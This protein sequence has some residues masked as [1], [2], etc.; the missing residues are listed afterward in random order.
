MIDDALQRA[1]QDDHEAIVA[2][3]LAR[4]RQM[5]ELYPN[6]WIQVERLR[7]RRGQPGVP[8]WPAWCYLP[9]AA[10]IAVVK[11][12]DQN[13]TTTPEQGEH[14]D[15]MAALAAWRV[16]RGVY[17]YDSTL[18]EELWNTP[19][20]G[21]LPGEILEHLP[22]WC[23]YVPTPGA[24]LQDTEVLGF[25]AHLQWD[26]RKR[27]G[28]KELWL[29]LEYMEQGQ[30]S[31]FAAALPLDSGGLEQA[32]RAMYTRRGVSDS[33]IDELSTNNAGVVEPFVS[34]LL[35]LCTQAAE[36]E[37]AVGT[38]RESHPRRPPR[39]SP[40]APVVWDVGYRLGAALRTPRRRSEEEPV[41]LRGSHAS[42]RPHIRRAHWHTYLTGPRQGEQ[43]RVLRWLPPLPVNV[44]DLDDL[45][46]TIHRVRTEQ[47]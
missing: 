34:I 27:A 8:D 31:T 47:P 13:R 16:T 45:P 24:H 6:A 33:Q 40:T 26:N 19:V 28:S 35:Y 41:A 17:R 29:L 10:V 12:L 37:R 18:L 36:I 3:P 2:R 44:E 11:E 42:P 4:L 39:R 14:V 46:A 20:E 32:L 25:F 43:E 5:R 38:E 7:K 21:D 9:L 1:G 23:V 22:E 15:I 30:P